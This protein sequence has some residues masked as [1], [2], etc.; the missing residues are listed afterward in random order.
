LKQTQ[1][2]V[3]SLQKE[4]QKQSSDFIS[5]T[6]KSEALQR[7]LTAALDRESTYTKDIQGLNQQFLISEEV[8]Q[9]LSQQLASVT[10]QRDHKH[11]QLTSVIQINHRLSAQL[12]FLVARLVEYDPTFVNTA[13]ATA[14]STANITS[15]ASISAESE[16]V[17][18]VIQAAGAGGNDASAAD[19]TSAEV[20]VQ[21]PTEDA[22]VSAAAVSAGAGAGGTQS[23]DVDVVGASDGQ[24]VSQIMTELEAQFMVSESSLQASRIELQISMRE[25]QQ[26]EAALVEQGLLVEGLQRRLSGIL[27]ELETAS[28]S[29]DT[30]R[31]QMAILSADLQ[32]CRSQLSET[33]SKLKEKVF[34][35]ETSS[36]ELLAMRG[37]LQ[38]ANTV[39]RQVAQLSTE[40]ARAAEA[41]A[42]RLVAEL[43]ERLV[44]EREEYLSKLAVLALF[45]AEARDSEAEAIQTELLKLREELFKSRRAEAQKDRELVFMQRQL[46]DAAGTI[47]RLMESGTPSS[48]KNVQSILA[49][50]TR[51][52]TNK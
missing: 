2:Q 13:T 12:R 8:R 16:N 45:E 34:Q 29:A 21:P 18:D 6:Q 15:T 26:A 44:M 9:D 43:S 37:S 52:I 42:L 31:K 25:K 20:D 38:S 32:T 3:A 47:A 51:K 48:E 27:N 30:M 1:Q 14:S 36:A 19:S 7:N 4:K 24:P 46:C 28:G 22:A 35:C 10:E 33:E 39:K 41:Q 49:V 50:A 23:G 5:L 11:E 40:H 17:T